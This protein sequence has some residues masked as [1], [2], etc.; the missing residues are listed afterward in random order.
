MR[1]SAAIAMAIIAATC[2]GACGGIDASSN[3]DEKPA[4]TVPKSSPAPSPLP[5]YK[6]VS[7]YDCSIGKTKRYAVEIV[8]SGHSTQDQRMAIARKEIERL[9]HKR[10]FNAAL[11]RFWW[12]RSNVGKGSAYGSID[13]APH[14]VWDNA[15]TVKTGDYHTMKYVVE[16]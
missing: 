3:A 13:Y 16:F 14:G 11:A 2:L 5:S 10:P 12:K 1:R 8:L 7:V 4:T 9:K 15:R 6:V